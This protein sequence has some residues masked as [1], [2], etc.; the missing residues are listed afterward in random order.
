MPKLIMLGTNDRYRTLDALNLYWKELLR[1]K[2]ILYVPTPVMAWPERDGQTAS[3]A[4]CVTW[5]EAKRYRNF[6][7]AWDAARTSSGSRSTRNRLQQARNYGG[8]V[9]VAGLSLGALGIAADA[10]AVGQACSALRSF[11]QTASW[12]PSPNCATACTA[13]T[14]PSPRRCISSRRRRQPSRCRELGSA[15]GFTWP[16]APHYHPVR[17]SSSA[18]AQPPISISICIVWCSTG[19]IAAP[20]ACRYFTKCALPAWMRY[21]PYWA[22]SSSA[23]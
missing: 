9:V 5:R 14:A 22:G 13:A 8:P 19:S 1:S 6:D 16:S 4:L 18:S 11:R 17:R 23:S 20:R 10:R 15:S 7:G 21:R 3:R 12:P 2:H